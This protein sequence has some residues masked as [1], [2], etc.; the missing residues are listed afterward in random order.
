MKTISKIKN[1]KIYSL[2]AVCVIAV[3]MFIPGC[4][5]DVFD[6]ESDDVGEHKD[7]A[8]LEITDFKNWLKS[9]EFTNEFVGKREPNWD[10]AELKMLRDGCTP[11]VS[12]EMYRGK[13][14][15][16][17]DSII[18]LQVVYVKNNFMGSVQVLSFNNEEHAHAQY[19]NLS[20]QIFDE[21]IYYAPK[22]LYISLEKHLI[23]SGIVRLKSNAELDN[24]TTSP[25]S[26]KPNSETPMYDANGYS[27]PDAYNCHY[28]VW[29]GL[30]EKND[31]YWP[32]W[33][34]WNECPNIAGSGYSEVTGT[35]QVGDRWVSWGYVPGY[36]DNHPVH[37][38]IVTQVTNG[39]VTQVEAKCGEKGIEYYN[40]NTHNSVYIR[41]ENNAGESKN[42]DIK[43][44]RE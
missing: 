43:Y 34:K 40:P 35:P 16:G 22:Q 25:D 30:D 33:P 19:Y 7:S 13:N 44:Y 12:I 15:L 17:N 9:Q 1:L 5:N 31:C 10:N 39:K 3:G 41:G 4:N 21:G 6:T 18:E 11:Q 28:Y 27:N 20:G 14:A 42:Y 26:I 24:N 2:I 29:G 23:T 37:S 32:S 8:S 36:G 38:A